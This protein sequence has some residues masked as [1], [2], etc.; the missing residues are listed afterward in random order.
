MQPAT[1]CLINQLCSP[2][3]GFQK[4]KTPDRLWQAIRNFWEKNKDRQEKEEWPDGN[5]YANHWS[6]PTYLV[7]IVEEKGLRG[8]GQV[9]AQSSWEATRNIMQEWCKQELEEVSMY[10]IR[11]YTEGSMLNPHVDQLPYVMSAVINIA[12]DVDEDWPFEVIGH[13][14]QA[15]NVTMKPGEMILYESHSILHGRPFSLQGRYYA[16][17]FVHFE[18]TGHSM[19]YHGYD[20]SDKKNGGQQTRMT[21]NK[22]IGGHEIEVCC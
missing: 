8:E 16:N 6:S 17:V 13:D 12:Q 5:T 7:R 10:G 3:K 19:K 22:Q 14:G 4:V 15:Y 20:G 18:P 9:L 1:L 11:V 2:Q 21:R